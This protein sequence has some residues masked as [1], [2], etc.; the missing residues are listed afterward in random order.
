ML[1]GCG[2][3]SS[4]AASSE[5]GSYNLTSL[6]NKYGAFSIQVATSGVGSYTYDEANNVYTL[7]VASTK[8]EYIFSGFFD[9]AIVVENSSGMASYKGVKIT[10]TD[11][12]LAHS[13]NR[14]TIDYT[15]EDKN[16]EIKSQGGT[17]NYV[18]NLGS[19][20][21]I[22]SGNN[23]EFSGKGDLELA[24]TGKD[25]HTVRASAD[26]YVYS[27]PSITVPISAH[28]AFHGNH[29]YFYEKDDV[30]NLYTGTMKISNV[31]SQ[32]FDFETS[33]GNGSINVNSG[34]IYVDNADSVFKTDSLLTIGSPASVIATNII[35]EPYV[36]GDNSSGLKTSFLGIFTVDGKEVS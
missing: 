27:A 4:S 33:G 15:L 36:Q 22:Y 32:A 16:V 29:L 12:C 26:V 11:A 5:A 8:A 1:I 17:Y 14:P 7:A 2:N 24:S 3:G 21:A 30:S 18:L 34:K 25:C 23:I 10:L 31:V 20:V 6:K 35:S 13:G 9:G 28:D 19:N